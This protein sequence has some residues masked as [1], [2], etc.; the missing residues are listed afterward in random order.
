[1]EDILSGL[2]AFLGNPI[3]ALVLSIIFYIVGNNAGKKASFKTEEQ[4]KDAQ[5]EIKNLKESIQQ[6]NAELKSFMDEHSERSHAR[7]TDAISLRTKENNDNLY[8]RISKEILIKGT[9]SVNLNDLWIQGLHLLNSG[10]AEGIGTFIKVNFKA[11]GRSDMLLFFKAGEHYLKDEYDAALLQLEGCGSE[12]LIVHASMLRG[13]IYYDR[14]ELQ[15][16]YESFKKAE[17]L[18]KV[19]LSHICAYTYSAIH[20]GAKEKAMELIGF[21]NEQYDHPSEALRLLSDYYAHFASLKDPRVADEYIRI[22]EKAQERAYI[23]HSI[24]HNAAM[25][26]MSKY[27][28]SKSEE[29]FNKAKTFALQ[30]KKNFPQVAAF[31][32]TLYDIY[33]AKDDSSNALLIV[34]EGFKT[35]SDNSELFVKY[36]QLLYY[37]GEHK[38]ALNLVSQTSMSQFTQLTNPAMVHHAV[39]MVYLAN[40]RTVEASGQFDKAISID[41]DCYEARFE[42]ARIL[43]F[44]QDTERKK[45]VIDHLKYVRNTKVADLY[46]AATFELARILFYDFGELAKSEAYLLELVDNFPYNTAHTELL[47]HVREIAFSKKK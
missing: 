43:Y 18:C 46:V 36:L 10:D 39:G 33:R 24:L 41:P 45:E 25:A 16:A 35:A 2:L 9:E 37:F 22:G 29:D 32:L 12:N 27:R 23:D 28:L 40:N 19:T 21:I 17:V 38:A 1:M 14:D 44:S 13:L 26:Y 7:Q 31:H 42:I 4:L 11:L 15:K 3:L 5:Q 34:K 30:G 20:Y 6:K 47:Q 8:Q